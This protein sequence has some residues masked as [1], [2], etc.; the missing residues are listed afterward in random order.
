MA[1]WLSRK[2]SGSNGNATVLLTESFG[3]TAKDV[4][5][6]FNKKN[7][8]NGELAEWLNATVLK[9]AKDVSPS[10]VRIPDSPRTAFKQS[11]ASFLLIQDGKCISLT[12]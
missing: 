4:S 10:G 1:E 6:S 9:T 2:L 12:F 7:Y 11:K 3:K 5:P 8:K